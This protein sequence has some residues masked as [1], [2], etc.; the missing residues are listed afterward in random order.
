MGMVYVREQGAT[1]RKTG[2]RILVEKNHQLIT[3]LLVID[4]STLIL[5]GNIQVTS[6][7]AKLFMENG[8]NVFFISMH[9]KIYGQIASGFNKNIFL[10]L[11]QYDRYKNDRLTIAKN[12]LVGKFRNQMGVIQKSGWQE[13][14]T[15]TNFC[16]QVEV[17]LE[18]LKH[19]TTINQANGIEGAV[20]R[21]YFEI[22]AG[23]LRKMTFET[24]K[25]RPAYDPVNA[26]LNFG[27]TLLITEL[28]NELEF[29]GFEPA[30]GF[31]HAI[32]YG[33]ISLACDLIEEFRAPII[34][35][36]VVSLI[37]NNRIKAD[38]FYLSEKGCRFKNDSLSK[39]LENYENQVSDYRPIFK[40]QVNCLRKSMLEG[41]NYVPWKIGNNI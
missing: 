39:F 32:H 22:F 17:A 37:N 12:F 5:I 8:I 26:M 1:I 24:R 27:Y 15:I 35:R 4:L 9:G 13:S 19:T 40:S 33:R 25:K 23:G 29:V 18:T 31:L 41:G 10:R 3:E 21:A 14:Q 11:A 38:D 2:Q 16:H 36:L 34:D 7:A 20:S 28:E 30:L 6:Q